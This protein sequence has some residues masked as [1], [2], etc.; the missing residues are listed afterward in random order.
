MTDTNALAETTELGVV[1]ATNNTLARAYVGLE[2]EIRR[3][4]QEALRLAVAN[5]GESYTEIEQQSMVTIESLRLVN[6]LDL[7]AVLLRG[8]LVREIE[9]NG[10]ITV[11]PAGYT[12]LEEMATDQGISVSEL[13]KTINLANVVF[14]HLRDRGLVIAELWEQIGKSKFSEMLPHLRVLI[15]N[16][17]SQSEQVNSTVQQLINDATAS[18]LATG[19]DL[20]DRE[21]RDRVV[22]NLIQDGVHLNNRQLRQ[23]LRPERTPPA[24]VTIIDADGRRHLIISV[25]EDQWRM[26]ERKLGRDASYQRFMLP[27]DP[28]ARRIEAAQIPDLR[29]LV[30]IVEG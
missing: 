6:G 29:A 27:D 2:G 7:T 21:I 4:A 16:E 17:E 5:S 10:Y 25:S 20:T 24:D 9:E 13:S 1:P 30:N 26:V 3:A 11:H 12:S 15:L 18:A 14:P 19:E 28:G 8:K 23:Q 22:L